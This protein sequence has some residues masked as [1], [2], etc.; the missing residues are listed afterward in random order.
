MTF[1]RYLPTFIWQT[2]GLHQI[3]LAV[4]SVVALVLNTAPIEVQ[5]RLVNDALKGSDYGPVLMLTLAYVAMA[6]GL[7]LTKL[8]LNVYRGW[9]SEQT[10]LKLRHSIV[11]DFEQRQAEPFSATQAQHEGVELSMV[12]AEVEP[13]GGFSG[14][15]FSEPLLQGGT[16]L[17]TLGYMVILQ[18]VMAIA[19]VVALLP[20]VVAVPILQRAINP[21]SVA[22]IA[23][24]RQVG[25][26]IVAVSHRLPVDAEAVERGSKRAFGFGMSIYWLTYILKF[27]MNTLH[28]LGVAVVLGLGGY[29]V[30][31]G[32]TSVGTVVAF[33]SALNA[34]NDP[35]GDFVNCFRDAAVT[36]AKYR[37]LTQS[38]GES[39][40]TKAGARAAD[41][42]AA[43]PVL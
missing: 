4:L 5:R 37:L 7:G 20:Q 29:Y 15:S 41:L 24:L 31:N 13:I 19:G 25:A 35:A 27:L 9:V 12:I 2:S 6:V 18:P 43:A 34:L 26:G 39:G 8:V 28:H 36:G 14:I 23:T 33:L 1:P 21:R 40:A 42:E 38:L 30:V 10:V 17:V 16:L 22:R 32:S 11:S 3:G